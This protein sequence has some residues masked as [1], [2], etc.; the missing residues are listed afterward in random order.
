MAA[1]NAEALIHEYYSVL[2][3]AGANLTADLP[4]L[5]NVA[6]S[7]DLD[8]RQNQFARWQRDGWVQK[9]STEL[10]QI[11]VQS[12]NLD[13]SDPA[14]GRVPAVQIDVCF[15]VTGVDVVDASGASVVAAAR[16]DLGWIRH[17]VSNYSW[18]T[19]PNGG[20][21]VSTSLDLEKAPCVATT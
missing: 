18:D 10:P 7:R 9:G 5:T 13:N 4:D 2:D 15:D 3:A 12:V 19:D 1:A 20:W 8:V 21:R 16:P 17:T 14:N 11:Q 6:I